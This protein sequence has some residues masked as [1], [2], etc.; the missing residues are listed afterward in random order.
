M[1]MQAAGARRTS[2]W[3]A[4]AAVEAAAAWASAVHRAPGPWAAV[5]TA[6]GSAQARAG[7]R[8]T[9]TVLRGLP[10]STI[11]VGP[12]P[13]GT[14]IARWFGGS[15]RISPW[16]RA[17][18]AVLDLPATTAEYLSGRPRQAMRT[19]I[20]RARAAGLTCTPV[21]D[22][23]GRRAVVGDVARMRAQDPAA[24]V[25]EQGIEEVRSHMLVARTEQGEAVGLAEVVVDGPVAG[26]ATLVTAPGNPAGAALRYLLHLAVVEHVLERQVRV[27][28]VSGSMLLTPAGT[29]YF[30]R[31][32]GFVPARVRLVRGTPGQPTRPSSVGSAAASPGCS[33]TP[34]SASD[35]HATSVLSR[36][37]TRRAGSSSSTGV[38]STVE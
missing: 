7:L 29:R 19:N 15:A 32:T 30:Q 18:V 28:V 37:R 3:P 12:G 1:G 35:T 20:T 22:E 2:D 10:S 33:S 36:S 17:P 14:E 4:D 6:V 23:A 24:M 26:L 21:L 31:R 34:G 16:A 13:A 5:R 9:L 8:A 25:L 11:P 27:L 38:A